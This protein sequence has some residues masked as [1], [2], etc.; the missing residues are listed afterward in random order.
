[1][2]FGMQGIYEEISG[3]AYHCLE[4]DILLP[5]VSVSRKRHT[6]YIAGAD[7]LWYTEDLRMLEHGPVILVHSQQPVYVAPGTVITGTFKNFKHE[8][9]WSNLR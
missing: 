5:S 2:W 9:N 4:L 3:Y 8:Q 1:M 7:L 6:L